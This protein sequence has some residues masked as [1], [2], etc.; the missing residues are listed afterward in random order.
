MITIL[1]L[2]SMLMVFYFIF[3]GYYISGTLAFPMMC[4]QPIVRHWYSGANLRR[5]SAIV[6]H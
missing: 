6:P 5:A 1:L 4:R 3:G 2:K